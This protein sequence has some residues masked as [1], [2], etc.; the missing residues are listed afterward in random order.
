MRVIALIE[1]PG[2][3]LK[4]LMRLG[5][6][7]PECPRRAERAPPG[8]IE[9]PAHAAVPLSYH[10]L[11]TAAHNGWYGYNLG[12]WSQEEKDEADLAVQGRY[13]ETGAKQLGQRKKI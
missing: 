4:I 3:A 13:Y 1:E 8:S 2:V 7:S 9:H 10:P 6:W 11:C 5:L 12:F